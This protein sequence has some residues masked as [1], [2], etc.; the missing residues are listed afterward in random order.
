MPCAPRFASFLEFAGSAGEPAGGNGRVVVTVEASPGQ[1][2]RSQI[3]AKI[4]GKG[5]PLFE[6]RGMSLSLEEIFLELTTEDSEHA[7]NAPN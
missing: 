7:S 4:V 6:L 2:L 5:W 3:A 1:D